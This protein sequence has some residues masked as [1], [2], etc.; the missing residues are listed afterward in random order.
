MKVVF[1]LCPNMLATSVTLPL[2][3][4][5][6]AEALNN[7]ARDLKNKNIK[8]LDI[9]LASVDGKPVKTHTG[10]TLNADCAVQD[11][12][13]ADIVY[14]P[15]LWRNPFPTV[16]GSPTTTAW[17]N[18]LYENGCTIAGVG[19]GCCFMAE[20]GLLDNKPATTHWHFF[21][22][23]QH[24]YP[25][26]Q[27]KRQYFITQAG[28]L[29][30]T[31]SVNALADLTVLFIQRYYSKHVASHVERHFF[32]EIRQAYQSGTSLLEQENSHPDE[33]IIQT[34]I[35][36]RDNFA[37]EIKLNDVAQLFSMS[38]RTFTRRFKNATGH[39]PLHYLQNIRIDVAK[40]LLQT[41]NLSVSEIMF[42][43]G[44]HDPTHFTNLFKKSLG[45]T[46]SQYRTTVRAKLFS[47]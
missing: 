6:A 2:E 16:S 27:L 8:A 11:C 35:W 44:Y 14:L 7:S 25:L 20:A 15:A 37:K 26:V 22:A 29:Y 21:D 45:V 4:L 32:H 12:D 10:L 43:V 38:P 39:T 19:T 46:P 9:Q 28:N 33:E 13:D 31:G 40:D 23:F 24:R 18:N 34:Q 47:V 36:L 42:R 17:L 5:R 30:C 41:S 1:L 3:L